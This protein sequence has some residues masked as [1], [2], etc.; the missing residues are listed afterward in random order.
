MRN[1]SKWFISFNKKNY[2]TNWI[3]FHFCTRFSFTHS[4]SNL[5]FHTGTM[6]KPT[7]K[8]FFP[9]EIERLLFSN[10]FFQHKPYDRQP[11]S[12][13]VWW[14]GVNPADIVWRVLVQQGIFLGELKFDLASN[15]LFI[16]K[17]GPNVFRSSQTCWGS[18]QLYF[19]FTFARTRKM[20]RKSILPRHLRSALEFISFS[21]PLFFRKHVSKV[22]CANHVTRRSQ[23]TISSFVVP[24]SFRYSSTSI[25]ATK[26]QFPDEI[27]SILFSNSFFQHKTLTVSLVT[28]LRVDDEDEESTQWFKTIFATKWNSISFQTH[29]PFIWKKKGTPLKI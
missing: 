28:L 22:D 9:S 23:R 12:I 16:Y 5:R 8:K 21:N 11:V 26:R 13:P 27:D 10:S 25:D 14:G 19:V 20:L 1:Q 29:F 3:G 15:T 4:F 6:K 2:S 18:Q 24:V 7:L 17:F